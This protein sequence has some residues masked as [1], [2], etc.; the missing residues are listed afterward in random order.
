MVLGRVDPLLS[1]ADRLQQLTS[2]IETSRDTFSTDSGQL[3]NDMITLGNDLLSEVNGTA[4]D[5]T[6][7]NN[8]IDAVNAEIYNVRSEASALSASDSTYSNASQAFG[9]TA[10]QFTDAVRALQR[11]L[12]Q[13]PS[14]QP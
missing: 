2:G 1:R 14:A 12:K 8:E 7:V 11:Q 3:V 13:V 6:Y 9:T 10:T 5:P 4:L